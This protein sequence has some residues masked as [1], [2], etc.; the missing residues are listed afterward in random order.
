MPGAAQAPGSSF[1]AITR[2]SAGFAFSNRY[3]DGQHISPAEMLAS[4]RRIARSVSVPVT[5]DLEAWYGDVA[6]TSAG[7]VESGAAGLTLEHRD[8]HAS[9]D[10]VEIS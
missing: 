9:K 6:A 1:P 8:D 7:S 5:A 4:A 3:P 2:T 10:L